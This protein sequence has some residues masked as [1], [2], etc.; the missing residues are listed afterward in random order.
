MRD[1]HR[2]SIQ[3]N[4][5]AD[6]HAVNARAIVI[7]PSTLTASAVNRLQPETKTTSLM[8]QASRTVASAS[9]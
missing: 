8:P 9:T 7:G 3:Q 2:A 4:M 1:E 6:C 5:L